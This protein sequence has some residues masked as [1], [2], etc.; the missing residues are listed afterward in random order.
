MEKEYIEAVIFFKDGSK[1][2]VSPIVNSD[3]DIKFD[4]G[5]IVIDNGC[6]SYAYDL[7]D[8]EKILLVEVKESSTSYI[9]CIY[10]DE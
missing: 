3:D 1:D 6:Y 5:G 9:G 2:W 4:D 8:I 7:K 10:G